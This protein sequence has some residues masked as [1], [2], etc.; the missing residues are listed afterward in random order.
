[1]VS[2]LLRDS[3]ATSM[4]H[5]LELR[6]PFVDV[7]VARFARRC[8]DHLKLDGVSGEAKRVLSDALADVIPASV[9]GRRKRGFDL[10]FSTWMTGDV[11]EILDDA[12]GPRAVASRGL[13][14]PKVVQALRDGRD[15]R[16]PYPKLWA[17][18]VLE[19]WA[20]AVLDVAPEHVAAAE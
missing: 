5:S 6:V 12:C 10:P 2:Q 8:P 11:R 20:R 9:R 14:N 19:L 13:L 7:E 17:L 18:M 3:D 4:A 1:M 16:A 15:P